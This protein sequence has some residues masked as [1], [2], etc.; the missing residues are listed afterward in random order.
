MNFQIMIKGTEVKAVRTK[1]EVEALGQQGYYKGKIVVADS[2]EEAVKLFEGG[3]QRKPANS[4]YNANWGFWILA[5]IIVALTTAFIGSQK[6]NPTLLYI[7]GFGIAHLLF[8]V[9]IVKSITQTITQRLFE[10]KKEL[11]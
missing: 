10:L 4:E 5:A 11:K 2:E 8:I 9:G 1:E 6:Y 3:S 7:I